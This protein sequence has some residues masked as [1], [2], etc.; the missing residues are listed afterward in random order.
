M[1]HDP[2][3]GGEG[4][5]VFCKDT[6]DIFLSSILSWKKYCIEKSAAQ[7]SILWQPLLV[8]D[9]RQNKTRYAEKKP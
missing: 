5:P 1:G 4:M 6:V 8:T 9:F 3:M 7:K 2:N